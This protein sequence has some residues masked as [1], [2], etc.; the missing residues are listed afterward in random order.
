VTLT[1][2]EEPGMRVANRWRG[3]ALA[4]IGGVALAAGSLSAHD[5][6]LKLDTY[7]LPPE[8]SVRVTILNGTFTRSEGVVA[9]DRLADISLVGPSGR[10]VLDTAAV[11]G[12]QKTSALRLSTGSEGTYVLGLSVRPREISLAGEQFNDYL[13]EEGIEDVLA[14][15]TRDGK[16]KE[17]ARERY[18]KHV[19]AVLQV[20]KTRTETAS[21]VL[22]YA[23]EIIPLDNPYEVK[24][25]GTLRLR[26]LIGGRPVGNLVVIAGGLGPKEVALK[27]TR[28]HTDSDG[29]VQLP[30]GVAGR[31]YAKF[32]KME[33]ST[34]P[35]VD[36]ESQW[37]TLTFEVR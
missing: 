21:T 20:G 34:L 10:R 8:T 27:E 30:L 26:C 9:R 35:G 29:V 23:A 12:R 22:G 24:R 2:Q 13:K 15:R 36:Y 25:G 33:R 16:L 7:F 17:P 19:K 4:I 6:F 18:A 31:W 14:Q 32:V 11:T 1:T 5:L 3:L 28:M 37:A